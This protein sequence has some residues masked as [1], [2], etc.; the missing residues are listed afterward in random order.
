MGMCMSLGRDVMPTINRHLIGKLM[1]FPWGGYHVVARQISSCGRKNWTQQRKNH[2]C[3]EKLDCVF[4]CVFSLL[5]RFYKIQIPTSIKFDNFQ[6]VCQVEVLLYSPYIGQT[7]CDDQPFI[8]LYID[9]NAA[10]TPPIDG[11]FGRY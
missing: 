11:K 4:P 3:S 10:F 7:L 2:I 6:V 5:I 1:W 8:S 9:L